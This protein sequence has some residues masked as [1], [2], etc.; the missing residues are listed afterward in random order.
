MSF[1][2]SDWIVHVDDAILVVNKPPGLPTLPD[3][4]NHSVPH[5]KSILEPD[6]GRL[7][8]VHRLDRQTSGLLV[9]A[10]SAEAHRQLN[11]QFERHQV[12]KT[13]HALVLGNPTWH[14]KTVSLPLRPNGDRRHRTVVD[15]EHGK[16]A[17]TEFKVIQRFDRD[18]CL[19]EAVPRSGR[20]HQIR[21]HLAAVGHPLAADALY[22]GGKCLW[23]SQ[24]SPEIIENDTPILQRAALHALSLEITHPTQLELLKF[25]STYPTDLA[26]V[27]HLLGK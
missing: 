20:T 8:I 7:W 19:V 22:G 9:L 13:Y 23:L 11:L 16:A 24:V 15:A 18:L 25:Y 2:T 17:H 5:V 10:R 3:G 6:F 26:Q 12:T 21:T 14:E 4:Y 1:P 27:L